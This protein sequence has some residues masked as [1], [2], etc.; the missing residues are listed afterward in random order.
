M[1]TI[2]TV[3]EANTQLNVLG[4]IATK[5]VANSK[6]HNKVM[7]EMKE[8]YTV[9]GTIK[10]SVSSQKGIEEGLP[11]VVFEPSSIVSKDYKAVYETLREVM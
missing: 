6:S 9:L 3:K 10:N 4:I 2:N 5:Y 11:C 8:N 1:D 7:N